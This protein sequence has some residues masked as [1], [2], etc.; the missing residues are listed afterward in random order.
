MTLHQRKSIR[1]KV[2]D[3]GQPGK[4]F[5]TICTK[6]RACIL[7][8]VNDGEMKLSNVGEIVEECWKEIPSHFNNACTDV[9]Q[10]MPNHVH[11][12]VAIKENIVGINTTIPNRSIDRRDDA[13]NVPKTASG[14]YSAIS[15]KH[16]SL[17]TFI[18]SFK[19]AVTKRM[20]E[21]VNA[22]SFPLTKSAPTNT[23]SPSRAL[24]RCGNESF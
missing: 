12:I 15:P 23:I 8:E 14:Y 19:S 10:I 4:Y 6:D 18:R 24:I 21:H 20:H 22:S 2:Y 7:G 5:V 13:C 1:L 11:G 16:H 3:Y 17:S 9:F